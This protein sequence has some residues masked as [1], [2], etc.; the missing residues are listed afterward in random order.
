MDICQPSS[1]L[2]HFAG[3]IK[4]LKC[5]VILLWG[6]TKFLHSAPSLKNLTIELGKIVVRALF[7]S[8]DKYFC[9][10]FDIGGWMPLFVPLK[11]IVISKVGQPLTVAT[12]GPEK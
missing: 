10:S 2:I 1:P 3:A 6:M 5:L 4:R 11:W 9:L 8:S 12:V 7:L